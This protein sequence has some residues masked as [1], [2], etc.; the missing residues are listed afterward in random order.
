MCQAIGAR[1]Q[2]DKLILAA[3]FYNSGW[4]NPVYAGYISAGAMALSFGTEADA[5][6]IG[7][8]RQPHC[9]GSA[10]AGE[11]LPSPR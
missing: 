5:G 1:A 10:V 9:A 4:R 3:K 7:R 6:G 2:T 11:G 8:A